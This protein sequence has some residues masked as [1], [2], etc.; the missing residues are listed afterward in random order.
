M[1]LFANKMNF[2]KI[3][4]CSLYFIAIVDCESNYKNK[5]FFN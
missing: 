2:S 4:F 5:F 1:R 3:A